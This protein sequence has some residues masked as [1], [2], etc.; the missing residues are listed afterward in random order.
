MTGRTAFNV[1]SKI[2]RAPMATAIVAMPTRIAGVNSAT[3]TL[4]VSGFGETVGSIVGSIV[5]DGEGVG[6]GEG[7]GE[8]IGVG[9][10]EG[11]GLREGLGLGVG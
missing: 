1:S 11:E 6:L 8:G 10:E 5:G 4:S 7:E 9:D 2:S 3:N